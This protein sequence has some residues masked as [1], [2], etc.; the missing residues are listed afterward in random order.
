MRRHERVATLDPS[1]RGSVAPTDDDAA[2][3]AVGLVDDA[4]REY[5]GRELVDRIDALGRLHRVESPISE[6]P[7]APGV[8]KIVADAEHAWA[9]QLVVSQ[10]AVIDVLLDVRSALV[11]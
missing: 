3:A 7:A 9:D 2:H 8:V 11:A 6:L 10:A 4:L 5:S 1:T